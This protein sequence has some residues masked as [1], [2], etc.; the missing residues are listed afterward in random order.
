LAKSKK[1]QRYNQILEKSPAFNNPAC[2]DNLLTDLGL[3]PTEFPSIMSGLKGR[4][5]Q[6]EYAI[7]LRQAQASKWAFR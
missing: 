2:I 1:G 5:P 3:D 7:E 4:F 6:K